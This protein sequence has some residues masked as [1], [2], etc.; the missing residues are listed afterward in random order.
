MGNSKLPRRKRSPVKKRAPLAIKRRRAP[1]C[2]GTNKD[3]TKCMNP[4]YNLSG[5]CHQHEKQSI[6]IKYKQQSAVK[7]SKI[8]DGDTF[9]IEGGIII[10]PVGYNTPEK[11]E[12]GTQKAKQELTALI[13]PKAIVKI[14]PITKDSYGR[15][16][17]RV[18][19][20][21]RDLSKLMKQKGWT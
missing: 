18:I 7:V 11:G 20:S 9:E 19:V 21:G 16:L 1:Y 5:F 15:V 13:S 17:A 6:G 14:Y 3:G 10:R 8:I 12:K 4:T 2:K